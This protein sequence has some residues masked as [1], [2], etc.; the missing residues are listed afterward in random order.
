MKPDLNEMKPFWMLHGTRQREPKSKHPSK[1]RRALPGL[2][3]RSAQSRCDF[4]GTRGDAG[5][6][7]E[8]VQPF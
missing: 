1:G 3:P 4:D 7:S 6:A 2:A 8:E 5:G